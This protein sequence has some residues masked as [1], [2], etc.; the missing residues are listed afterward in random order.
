MMKILHISNYYPPHVGG[1]EKLAFDIVNILNN[2]HDQKVICFNGN[3]KT[4]TDFSNGVEVTRIGYFL[5]ISSQAIAFNYYKELKKIINNFDP[6]IIHFHFP[7]PF[8]SLL[9]LKI[10]F[11]AKLIVHWNIEVTKQKFLKIFIKHNTIELLKRADYI[12]TS[13]QEMVD[14]SQFLSKFSDKCKIIPYYFDSELCNIDSLDKAKIRNEY[15]GKKICLFIGRLVKQKRVDLLINSFSLIHSKSVLLIAGDGKLRKKLEKNAPPNV[16]FLGNVDKKQYRA[17]IN[18][19]DLFLLSSCEKNESFS[20]ALVD[21]LSVG[22]P[23]ITYTIS[24]S[25]VN[26]VNLNDVTGYQAD[27]YDFKMFS[28]LTE[29]LLTDKELYEKFSNAAQIRTH[30]LF[31]KEVFENKIVNLFLLGED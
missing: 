26:Y 16:I 9:L 8:V 19:C 7:N 12:Y 31:S 2:E 6:D 24:G 17:L 28:E 20:L 22:K 21:A 4:E 1:V 18:A 23:A 3:R 11:R 10:K 25:S 13:S 29:K 15:I 27:T 30:K 14:G 5:K